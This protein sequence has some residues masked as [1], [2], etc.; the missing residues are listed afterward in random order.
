M[1]GSVTLLQL[2]DSCKDRADMTGSNRIGDSQWN[3]YINKSKDKLY[4]LLISAYESEYYT[5]SIQL[6][7]S[8]NTDTYAL[9]T[10]FYKTVLVEYLVDT[11]HTYPLK[12]FSFAEKN[13]SVYPSGFNRYGNYLRYREVADN[14]VFHPVP[15]SNCTVKIWYIPTATNL[16]ADGDLL[17]GFNGWEE[18][19]IIDV[20]IKAGRNE[21]TD[22]KDLERDL[23][24]ITDRLNTMA[25]NRNVN[26]SARIQNVDRNKMMGRTMFEDWE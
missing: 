19:I 25:E 23:L 4:D 24:N 20:A 8:A 21:E 26:C 10:D 5:K 7:V 13:R 6:D 16:S 18:F 17:K 2:R 9:P 14:I 11:Y 22:T 1:S 15:V 3:E 12:K